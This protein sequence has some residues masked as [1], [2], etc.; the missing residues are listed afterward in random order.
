M[1]WLKELFKSKATKQREAR[2]ALEAK[3]LADFHRLQAAKKRHP[4][5]KGTAP[6]AKKSV[7]TKK[8]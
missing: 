1:N 5:G 6:V 8:K 3:V 4:A 2:E 7:A